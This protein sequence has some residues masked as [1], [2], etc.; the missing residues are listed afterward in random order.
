M[1]LPGNIRS[2]WRSRAGPG[3][4]ALVQLCH[5]STAPGYSAKEKAWVTESISTRGRLPKAF[6]G[7]QAFKEDLKADGGGVQQLE[8]EK[9]FSPAGVLPSRGWRAFPFGFMFSKQYYSS[10]PCF[11]ATV[12]DMLSPIPW[13]EV[14]SSSSKSCLPL[15]SSCPTSHWGKLLI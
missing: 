11:P 4:S 8:L 7:F 9:H 13:T 14:V 1:L 5:M 15:I 2:H 3:D 10:R 12:C 6:R